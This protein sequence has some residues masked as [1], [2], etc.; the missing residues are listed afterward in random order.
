ML[1]GVLPRLLST[2]LF[3]AL[4]LPTGCP[5]KPREVAERL[6]AVPMP[7]KLTVCGLLGSLS[8]MTR[9]ADRTPTALG[10]NVKLIVQ[11]PSPATLPPATHVELD[12]MAKST[13]F[14]PVEV[15]DA[16]LTTLR[17]EMLTGVLPRF[18]SV[19]VLGALLLS[20]SCTPKLSD[21]ADRLTAIPV[22]LRATL[23]GLFAAL[24]V[25]V[26]L[27]V[28]FPLAVGL[29]VTLSA[30]LPLGITVAPVQ[31]SALL[32]KSPAF[33]PVSPTLAIVR[34]PL[35]LLVTVSVWA[36]LVVPSS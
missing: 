31:V 34:F 23:C 6:T 36:A 25:I 24:S 5:P 3:G 9:V 29:K 21:V 2:M 35:P 4:R 16:T 15:A 13:A 32:A 12:R 22:P 20:T 14:V 30:Q 17:L 7:R 10:L 28:L 8:A 26:R 1:S 18:V 11:L 19:T 27:A 33:V